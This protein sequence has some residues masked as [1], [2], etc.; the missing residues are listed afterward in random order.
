VK[1]L[2]LALA[3]IH[4]SLYTVATPTPGP[5]QLNLDLLEGK[6]QGELEYLD[7]SDGKSKVKISSTFECKYSKEERSLAIAIQFR[8]PS[9]KIINDESSITLSENGQSASLDGEDWKVTSAGATPTQGELLIV[10]E[11]KGADND[12]PADLRKTIRVEAN[13]RFT[14]RKEVKYQGAAEYFTRNE[15]RLRRIK[16]K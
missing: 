10:L 6:W 11:R 8:E 15:Y 14:F 9:G 16:S 5:N 7:F 2:I 12:K 4:L 1:I 13:D 3:A